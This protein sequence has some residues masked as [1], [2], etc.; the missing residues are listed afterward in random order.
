MLSPNFLQTM[1][2]LTASS[3]A[4][5]AVSSQSPSFQTQESTVMNTQAQTT[6]TSTIAQ[7]HAVTTTPVPTASEYNS[8]IE[9]PTPRCACMVV[10]DTSGSMDGAPIAQLNAGIQTFVQALQQDDMAACSVEV[11]LITAGGRVTELLPF[12]TAMAVDH[13]A[14]VYATGGTPLGEA[15]SLALR[16]LEERKQQYKK[17]GVSYYQP[18]LMIISDGAPTDHWESAARQAYEQSA[19]RKLVVLPVAVNGADLGTLGQFSAKGA[20]PLEGLRFQELFQW[21]SA[22]MVRVSASASTSASVQLPARDS[23]ASI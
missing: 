16:R 15:V 21:L 10:L 19:G 6:S 17:N 13:I 14:P 4:S 22:S 8:L 5:K 1:A 20:L 11:G 12:T 18:W 3:A 23:W 2:Q 9:N 7:E